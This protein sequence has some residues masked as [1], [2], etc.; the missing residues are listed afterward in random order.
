MKTLDSTHFGLQCHNIVHKPLLCTLC[1]FG[2]NIDTH[3]LNI[4]KFR[5]KR[6]GS[7]VLFFSRFLCTSRAAL[8]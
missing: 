2:K 8:A 1:N 5:Y 7:D 3:G 6:P 4:A